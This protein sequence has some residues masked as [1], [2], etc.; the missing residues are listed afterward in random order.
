MVATLS[1]GARVRNPSGIGAP[2]LRQG[3]LSGA[4]GRRWHI[5]ATAGVN[6]HLLCFAGHLLPSEGVRRPRSGGG[7]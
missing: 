2:I 7:L 6:P 4:K 5:A 1:H 3:R